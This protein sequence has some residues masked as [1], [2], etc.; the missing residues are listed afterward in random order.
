[1]K[2][3][4]LVSP[5]LDLGCHSKSIDDAPHDYLEAEVMRRLAQSYLAGTSPNDP[6]AS[7]LSATLTGLPPTFVAS[8][9]EEA[10][11]DEIADFVARARQVGVDVTHDA[12]PDL[13]HAYPLIPVF[14]PERRRLLHR[15]EDWMH[16]GS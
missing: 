11:R 12:A 6:R 14:G 10:F 3:L 13:P 9:A 1:V 2:R 15:L 5:W 8:G 4:I 16:V 7:P